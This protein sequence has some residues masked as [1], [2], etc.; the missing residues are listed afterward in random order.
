MLAAVIG[1]MQL[2]YNPES[3]PQRDVK[4]M[5]KNQKAFDSKVLWQ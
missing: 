3:Q 1:F 5:T 2:D 4:T